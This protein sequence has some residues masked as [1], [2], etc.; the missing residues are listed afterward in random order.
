VEALRARLEAENAPDDLLGD[1]WLG[2]LARLVP[3]LRERYPDLPTPADDPTL[4]RGRLFEAVARLGQ[5]LAGRKPLVLCLDDVQWTDVATRDL[6]RYTVR[7]WAESGTPVLVILTAR[8]ENLRTEWELARW[9]GGL[10]RDT[11]TLR[12]ELNALERRDVV[13]LVRLLAGYPLGVDPVDGPEGHPEGTRTDKVVEFG[14]WLGD[15]TAG[16]PFHLVQALHLL[17]EEEVLR[18]RPVGESGWA[19]DIPDVREAEHDQRLDTLLLSGLQTLT[20]DRPDHLIERKGDVSAAAAIL[21]GRFT[22]Q[23]LSQV[24][25]GDEDAA[26]CALD[27]LVQER[28]LLPDLPKPASRWAYASCSQ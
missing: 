21:R 26:L 8:V 27:L 4:G 16:H 15:R 28:V 6:V 19:I 25:S 3:E 24:A 13:Q 9:F 7:R 17:L 22:A 23:R 1:L 2:E 14:E 20:A 5:A 11:P 12:L 10:E 18:V